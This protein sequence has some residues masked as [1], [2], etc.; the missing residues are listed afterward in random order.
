MK[1]DIDSEA[2]LKAE[3]EAALRI[4]I[5][6]GLVTTSI[7]ENGEDVYTYHGD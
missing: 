7:D 3:V 2:F 4:L 5:E 1:P 6:Q